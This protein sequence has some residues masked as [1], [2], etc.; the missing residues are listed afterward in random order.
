MMG[1]IRKSLRSTA[2]CAVIISVAFGEEKRA[3]TPSD[4]IT[5]RYLEKDWSQRSAIQINPQ[6]T[7]FAYLV[8]SPNIA[9]NENEIALY[10]EKLSPDSETS[11]KPLVVS[12]DISAMQWLSDGTRLAVLVKIGGKRRIEIVNVSSG[13]R[14]TI[15]EDGPDVEEFTIAASGNVVVFATKHAGQ[16]AVTGASSEDIAKGYRIAFQTE[17][18]QPFTQEV[19]F[20]SQ[21]INGRWTAPQSLLVRSPFTHRP[22]PSLSILGSLHLSLSPDG[23]RLLFQEMDTGEGMASEWKSSPYMQDLKGDG[24][25]GPSLIALYDMKAG[26]TSVALNSPWG[27]SIPLWSSDSKSFAV[28]A[29]SPVGSVWEKRDIETND[30]MHRGHHLFTVEVNSGAVQEVSPENMENRGEQPLFWDSD[31]GMVVHTSSNVLETFVFG[32]NSWHQQGSM[33]IPLSD[34]YRFAAIASDGSSVVG[35]YQNTQ[36]PPALFLYRAGETRVEMRRRLNPEFDHL[37]L[38]PM[39][40]V[41]WTTPTGYHATG[42][43]FLPVNYV[44]GERYPLVVQTKLNEGSFVC[45]AGGVGHSPSFAPQPLANSG[46]M[47]LIGTYPE[48]G[49]EQDRFYPKGYPGQIAEAVFGMDL[50][51]SAVEALD[52]QGL[53]D[54]KRVGIIGFSRTGWHVEFALTHSKR[55]YAAATTADNVQYSLGEYWYMHSDRVSKMFESMYGGSPYGDAGE[56][57]KKYSVSFNLD[58][59]HTPLLM[60]EMGYGNKF[61]NA[62]E[63]P[64][65]LALSFEIFTALNRLNRPVELYYY[66]DEVHQPDHPQA[67]LASLERNVDWYRFWLQGFERA[68]PEDPEQY[69]RWRRMRALEEAENGRLSGIESATPGRH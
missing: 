69:E 14:E 2:I 36:T 51:D 65:N 23:E 12:S 59:L 22:L 35:E 28:V 10:V 44:E 11:V 64:D 6:D 50:W 25:S 67:R 26:E 48:S 58:R 42:F 39:R 16:D 19:I 54:P 37:T 32:A 8:R 63:P 68:N 47:Y 20:S 52:K 21:L 66:P 49:W 61:D 7:L 31:R 41:Q 18:V 55:H 30:L 56:T 46:I 45:D 34:L 40:Q 4:C 15:A 13:E 27:D 57:W 24:F 9:T 62:H 33:S 53:I 17:T 43:L 3:I 5:V 1:V 38:A 60:E 29:Q